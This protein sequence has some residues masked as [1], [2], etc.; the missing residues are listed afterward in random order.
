METKTL[1]VKQQLTMLPKRCL[2]DRVLLLYIAAFCLLCTTVL[3]TG[4]WF[5]ERKMRLQTDTAY[6]STIEL[7]TFR[8]R[9]NKIKRL[10]RLGLPTDHLITK[11]P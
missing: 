8:R 5:L 9:Q 1:T 11:Q 4:L 3:S 7:D 2:I 10:Y 6:K